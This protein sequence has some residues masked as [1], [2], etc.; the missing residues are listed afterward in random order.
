VEVTL[1]ATA[2]R[3][4]I[5]FASPHPV[6]AFSFEKESTVAGSVRWTRWLDG[7]INVEFRDEPVECTE[8]ISALIGEIERLKDLIKRHKYNLWGYD[9]VDHAEDRALYE[10]AKLDCNTI[11]LE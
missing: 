4:A 2:R 3:S 9:T 11:E 5:S 7:S 8:L 6:A 10:A 1:P